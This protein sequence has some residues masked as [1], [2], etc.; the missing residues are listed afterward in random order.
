MGVVLGERLLEEAQRLALLTEA[1][2][3][4]GKASLISTRALLFEAHRPL[5]VS[6]SHLH[7][8][9]APSFFLS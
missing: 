3:K 2:L 5:G 8:S 1:T 6:R 4:A 9:I 7:Q